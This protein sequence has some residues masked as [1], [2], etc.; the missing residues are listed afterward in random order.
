M[1]GRERGYRR[2]SIP[3]ES[4]TPDS[5]TQPPPP[6]FTESTG[7]RL[8]LPDEPQPIHFLVQLLTADIVGLIV[9]ETNR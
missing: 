8:D 1:T 3:W 2:S 7:P 4:T 9:M 6:S 5:D